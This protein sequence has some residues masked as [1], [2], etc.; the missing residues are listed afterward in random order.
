V[1]PLVEPRGVLLVPNVRGRV[2][3]LD[4]RRSS[5]G[6]MVVPLVDEGPGEKG[7]QKKG[8]GNNVSH[9]SLEVLGVGNERNRV[10]DKGVN[11]GLDGGS[12]GHLGALELERNLGHGRSSVSQSG[13]GSKQSRGSHGHHSGGL[14]S[15]DGGGLHCSGWWL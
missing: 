3:V 12:F 10:F 9:G 5:V 1:D 4:G 8:P 11:V 7:E 2:L 14:K 13:R 6:G 15:S